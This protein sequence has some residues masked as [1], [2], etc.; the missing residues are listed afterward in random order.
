M[1]HNQAH[2]IVCA[3]KF[4]VTELMLPMPPSLGPFLVLQDCQLLPSV[5]QLSWLLKAD[6]AQWQT[7]FSLT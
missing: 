4:D 7:S 1:L 3:N 5:A 2:N 6:T